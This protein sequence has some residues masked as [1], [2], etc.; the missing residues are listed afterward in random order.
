M[1]REIFL[2]RLR[3]G[4][5]VG[6]AILHVG[7]VVG[8]LSALVPVGVLDAD[9]SS[10]ILGG[11]FFGF[12]G[13]GAVSPI[14]LTFLIAH[15]VAG[16]A[17]NGTL[18]DAYLDGV[19]LFAL[20]LGAFCLGWRE[21][22]SLIQGSL[23]GGASVGFGDALRGG[24]MLGVSHI[25]GTGILVSGG[26]QLYVGL[27]AFGASLLARRRLYAFG[28]LAFFIVMLLLTPIAKDG[29]WTV[30][31]EYSLYSPLWH[32]VGDAAGRF[33]LDASGGAPFVSGYLWS[34]ITLILV[35]RLAWTGWR[36]SRFLL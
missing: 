35:S 4:T 9:D 7:V 34:L 22:S 32:I 27:V 19:N 23:L 8:A 14:C 26:V 20:R 13:A 5:R 11:A 12:L 21:W 10:G 29:D 17:Q 33:G 15:H 16:D 25:T 30:L 24:G 1:M 6:L 18:R 3:G 28:I 31:L 2:L 36:G